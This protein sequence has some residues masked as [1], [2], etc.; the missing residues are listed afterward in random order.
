M[1][2]SVCRVDLQVVFTRT[3]TTLY[4][5]ENAGQTF[6][7]ICTFP[8]GPARR[9]E[10]PE[11][12]RNDVHV[13]ANSHDIAV[14]APAPGSPANTVSV[15]VKRP[16]ANPEIVEVTFTQGA[17][18]QAQNAWTS[19]D[20]AADVANWRDVRVFV[21]TASP[22]WQSDANGNPIRLFV[23]SMALPLNGGNVRSPRIAFADVT[24]AGVLGSFGE[25]VAANL[26][27]TP[28]PRILVDGTTIYA[29]TWFGVYRSTDGC[30]SFELLADGL[31]NVQVRDLYLLPRDPINNQPPLLRA[32]TYGRGVWEVVLP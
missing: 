25:C 22:A 11:E 15:A 17:A 19:R 16:G 1:L 12:P 29:A 23:S 6:T 18:Q 21:T 3:S 4:R 10:E 30:G 20:V 24:A 5:S 26:P 7:T 27:D 28:I 32:G 8:C 13:A 2:S 14:A 9:E 31:P